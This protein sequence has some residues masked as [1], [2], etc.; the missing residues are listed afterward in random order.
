MFSKE[1]GY[2]IRQKGTLGVG[3]LERY[4]RNSRE[5]TKNAA[6][7]KR[8]K[9]GCSAL[10]RERKKQKKTPD[11]TRGGNSNDIAHG[12][13]VWVFAVIIDRLASRSAC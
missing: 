7:K 12:S 2:R 10:L 3:G 13:I 8:K 5:G 9:G 11:L 1:L 6:K 4:R